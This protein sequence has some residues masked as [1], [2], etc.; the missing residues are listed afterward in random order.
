MKKLASLFLTGCILASSAVCTGITASAEE[1][2][3]QETAKI[4]VYDYCGVAFDSTKSTHSYLSGKQVKRGTYEFEVGDLV[5][6]TV[7]YTS[8]T[9]S[10]IAGVFG[11]TFINQKY[12]TVTNKASF[13]DSTNGVCD[14]L[15][16]SDWYY[17]RAVDSNANAVYE[18]YTYMVNNFS[19][20]L[21]TS[22]PTNCNPDY[23]ETDYTRDKISFSAIT[24]AKE[25]FK[26][27]SVK[28]FVTFTVRVEEPGESFLYTVTED[29]LRNDNE[30]TSVTD[31]MRS[32]TSVK[33]VGHEAPLAENECEVKIFYDQ[34]PR[35][36]RYVKTDGSM[37]T[38]EA[39]A[40]SGKY[41]SH[42]ATNPEGTDV[43]STNSKYY[44]KVSN[45]TTLY[46]IYADNEND[47]MA[48]VP[49]LAVTGIYA[50]AEGEANNIYFEATRSIPDGY[51]LKKHGIIYGRNTSTFSANPEETLKL[52]LTN[53]KTYAGSSKSKNST[54]VMCYNMGVNK[55]GILWARGYMIVVNDSTNQEETIYT[56]V[57][58]GS[59]K[60][61][62]K[63]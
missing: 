35:Y 13:D 19:G 26:V 61:L 4:T 22:N 55:S 17:G 59:F 31:Q 7:S 40:I 1:T 28:K 20:G 34:D 24:A 18:P 23:T 37:A 16:L 21:L 56:D 10:A 27:S 53:V 44:F 3:T 12:R 9:E 36:R 39:K 47:V 29:A 2:T 5:N 54:D 41:F 57:V 15:S 33:K 25:G 48:K 58:S 50:K 8:K 52:G 60:T 6:V 46:A 14:M 45:N 42:W 49:A 63:K 11:S 62:P 38:F 43:V 30:L 32:V 51:T